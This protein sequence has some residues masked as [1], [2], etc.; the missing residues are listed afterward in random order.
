M[1]QCPDCS[2]RLSVKRT[3]SAGQA[4]QTQETQC[5]N[6]GKR[7]AAVTILLR[8]VGSWGLGAFAA[9][10]QLRRGALTLKLNR[11]RLSQKRA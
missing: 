1:L 5:P 11:K 9:V 4:G 10:S 6:C 3:Y 8:E 2:N 7:F